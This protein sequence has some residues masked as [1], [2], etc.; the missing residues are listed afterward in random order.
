[1]KITPS[2]STG[3]GWGEGDKLKNLMMGS[4]PSLCSSRISGI[5]N[6]LFM[7]SL[8]LIIWVVFPLHDGMYLSGIKTL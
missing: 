1:M 3:E 4:F 5:E 8:S 7:S 6:L 2:P